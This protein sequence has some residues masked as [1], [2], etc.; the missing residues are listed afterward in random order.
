[1]FCY[2]NGTREKTTTRH[3]FK[4]CDCCNVA[5]KHVAMERCGAEGPFLVGKWAAKSHGFSMRK[6][7]HGNDIWDIVGIFKNAYWGGDILIG[8]FRC[9]DCLQEEQQWVVVKHTRVG[10]WVWVNLYFRESETEFKNGSTLGLWVSNVAVFSD[11]LPFSTWRS[12]Y[13]GPLYTHYIFFCENRGTKLVEWAGTVLWWG[14]SA[15][16]S[17]LKSGYF[18]LPPVGWWWVRKLYDKIWG[19]ALWSLWCGN[20]CS[21]EKGRQGPLNTAHLWE[22]LEQDPTLGTSGHMLPGTRSMRRFGMQVIEQWLHIW[23]AHSM[24]SEQSIYRI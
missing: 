22:E 6:I 18:N 16:L 8:F 24:I 2:I 11:N 3:T 14:E 20:P 15:I 23:D 9:W 4:R 21:P 10:I 12:S 13:T 7:S 19:S 5:S 1:M 17:Q